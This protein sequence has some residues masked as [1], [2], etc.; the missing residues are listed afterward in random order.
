MSLCISNLKKIVGEAISIRRIATNFV[1]VAMSKIN[2]GRPMNLYGRLFIIL[3]KT[4]WTRKFIAPHEAAVT[5]FTVLPHDLDFNL[6][7][8]NGRYLTLMDLAR[9]DFMRQTGIAF[10]TIKLKWFPILGETQMSFIRPLKVFDR[11]EIHTRIECM[12]DK[13]IIMSQN[14]VKNGKLMASGK[15]RGL[16]RSRAGNIPP[17][18]IVNLSPRHRD[19]QESKKD[20]SIFNRWIQ[21]LDDVRSSL[22]K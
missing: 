13:W 22:S 21:L 8:N 19:Y 3:F 15:I 9:F 4:L 11:F 6:H 10:A 20:N 5:R 14:F 12:D 1:L 2:W 18:D 16:L 7:M 17:M